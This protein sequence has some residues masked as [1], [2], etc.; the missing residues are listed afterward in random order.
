MNE[1]YLLASS[2]G[3]FRNPLASGKSDSVHRVQPKGKTKLS[4]AEVQ[5][6]CFLKSSYNGRAEFVEQALQSITLPIT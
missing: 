4:V 3:Q 5:A 2:I 6:W 1:L